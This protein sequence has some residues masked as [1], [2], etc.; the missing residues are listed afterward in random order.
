VAAVPD[1]R[2]MHVGSGSSGKYS[3]FVE[4]LMARNRWLFL[5]RN[6]T[7]GSTLARWLRVVGHGCRRAA[8]FEQL[9]RPPEVS[10]AILAGLSAA[11]QQRF[12]KPTSLG[13]PARL[14]R[15]CYLHPWRF[16][17]TVESLAGLLEPRAASSAPADRRS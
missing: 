3:P 5:K 6:A 2:A 7:G 1:A 9:G 13:P 8:W 12:G 10:A 15:L 4:F 16:S 17:S 14:E 11:R